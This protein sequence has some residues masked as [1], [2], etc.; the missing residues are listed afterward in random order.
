MTGDQRKHELKPGDRVRNS[1]SG[2]TGI[3]R[4]IC[5]EQG[6]KRVVWRDETGALHNSPSMQM[7]FCPTESQIAAAGEELK[8]EHIQKR[9]REVD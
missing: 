2:K 3:V 1:S 8:R 5:E 6:L 9:A 7:W 4:H